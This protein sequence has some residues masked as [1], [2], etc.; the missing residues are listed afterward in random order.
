MTAATPAQ[1]INIEQVFEAEC[2][3]FYDRLQEAHALCGS[4]LQRRETREQQA[5]LTARDAQ[6]ARV[7][8][9]Q[10]AKDTGDLAPYYEMLER[11]RDEAALGAT[12]ESR[13]ASAAKGQRI[14][15]SFEAPSGEDIKPASF[16]QA[17][18]VIELSRRLAIK[19]YY[20]HVLAVTEA[21]TA[22]ERAASIA[23]VVEAEKRA[24]LADSALQSLMTAQ[25]EHRS[26]TV[27]LLKGDHVAATASAKTSGQHLEIVADK[28]GRF[29]D[30][31][32]RSRFFQGTMNAV[33][34]ADVLAGRLEAG[35]TRTVESFSTGLKAF[36]G[37]IRELA[38]TVQRTPAVVAQLT[39]SARITV[40]QA[41][42]AAVTSA[43]DRIG[44]F[45][46]RVDAK[47]Q[48]AKSQ[49]SECAWAL[50]D[51]A[52]DFAARTQDKA[53]AVAETVERHALATVGLAGGLLSRAA[54]AI[55]DSAGAL[56]EGYGD[57]LK[58]VDA[59]RAQR[60]A[61][62]R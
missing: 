12:Q 2:Y 51:D 42:K 10:R 48:A 32:P 46:S 41:T 31:A 27:N 60:R 61:T 40:E 15:P 5:A 16:E 52:A 6:E 11:D 1:S 22:E 57:S 3:K 43:L 28:L 18:S 33:L 9:V 47:A 35:A 55:K 62:P 54:G 36:A 14:E 59:Q 45:L 24:R 8:I 23:Q 17:H 25:A 50:V 37:R 58:Q 34:K 26:S 30:G 21:K 20:T 39:Q 7:R 53:A 44:G 49:V 19:D 13:K 4:H 56:K 38:A 29:A